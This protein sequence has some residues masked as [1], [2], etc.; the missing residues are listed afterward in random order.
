[1]LLAANAVALLLSESTRGLVLS[2]LFVL[3]ARAASG[4]GLG[5][6]ALLGYAVAAFSAGRLASSF[7]LAAIAARGVPYAHVLSACFAIQVAGGLLYAFC[8]SGLGAGADGGG[9]GAAALLV[10]SRLVVGFGSGTLPTC[11]AVVADVTAPAE[12]TRAFAALSFAKY[13]GYALVPG[14]GVF[15]GEEPAT[16][17]I[18]G[19]AIAL[20]GLL[21]VALAFDRTLASKV[22]AAVGPAPLAPAAPGELANAGTASTAAAASFGTWAR[23]PAMLAFLVFLAVNLVT[24]GVLASAEAFL[25]PAFM[26]A[27]AAQASKRGEGPDLDAVADTAEF[28]LALGA[29]GLLAYGLMAIKPQRQRGPPS[30]APEVTAAATAR[31]ADATPAPTLAAPAAE[32][33][34]PAMLPFRGVS[35]LLPTEQPLAELE[36]AHRVA[37]LEAPLAVDSV[38]ANDGAQRLAGWLAW[39][40][41][42]ADELDV[43][44]LIASLVMT[45]LGAS[46]LG[47][48]RGRDLSLAELSVGLVLLWSLAAPVADVLSVSRLSVALSR[49]KP[50]SQ[51]LLMGYLTAGGSVGRILWPLGVAAL[52]RSTSNA[53]SAAAAL[54]CAV[55]VAWL[56]HAFSIL[57]GA[58]ALAC[59]PR[60]GG[61]GSGNGGN[62]GRSMR[63]GGFWRS[64][65]DEAGESEAEAAASAA[66]IMALPQ[67]Q[68]ALATD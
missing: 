27:N 22:E 9:G 23:S 64:F 4:S 52:G 3:A 39:A 28:A 36:L 67:P 46:V 55:A 1:L 57:P 30:S 40:Q 7:A 15:F 53:L 50:G 58:G 54:A 65:T 20:A 56:Y 32:A 25:A 68:R 44:M 26:S 24:K 51:A 17:A 5:G 63:R 43:L 35:M 8:S 59:L 48:G 21:V 66:A 34:A 16:P 12:R 42:Y 47:L 6:E 38:S 45:A 60:G 29:V 61:D 41:R 19:V 2:S 10:L 49:V 62:G 37:L 13:V 14:I 11:R 31:A 33:A 18:A